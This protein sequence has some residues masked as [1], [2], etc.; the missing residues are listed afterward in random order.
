MARPTE[1]VWQCDPAPSKTQ[2]REPCP[3]LP[4]SLGWEVL[5]TRWMPKLSPRPCLC[6]PSCRPQSLYS[7]PQ[8]L[9]PNGPSLLPGPMWAYSRGPPYQGWHVKLV[10]KGWLLGT[11]GMGSGQKREL[12][13]CAGGQGWGQEQKGDRPRSGTARSCAVT[14]CPRSLRILKSHM[15]FQNVVE[16][17]W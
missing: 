14:F 9:C 12:Q 1:S 2:A 8:N 4:V 13:D 6:L 16:V 17:Y 10:A 15:A 5:R 11:Q 3:G 7:G